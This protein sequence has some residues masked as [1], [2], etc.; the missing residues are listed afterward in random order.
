MPW[1][2]GMYL[3]IGIYATWSIKHIPVP[4]RKTGIEHETRL[5]DKYLN[6]LA[7]E[8]DYQGSN[9]ELRTYDTTHLAS[10]FIQESPPTDQ[11]PTI[12]RY[13]DPVSYS[14]NRCRGIFWNASATLKNRW[15]CWEGLGPGPEAPTASAGPCF[16]DGASKTDGP[17]DPS[18][19][20]PE[21]PGE[22]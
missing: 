13:S 20:Q 4:I 9:K 2:I 8:D 19:I 3:R 21:Q 14:E 6:H 18:Y 22:E 16:R 5:T 1:K 7:I 11:W 12:A 17:N 10:K 15:P